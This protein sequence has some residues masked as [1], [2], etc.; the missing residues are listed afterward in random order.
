MKEQILV[1]KP[2]VVERASDKKQDYLQP[3]K[4][5]LWEGLQMVRKSGIRNETSK[6]IFNRSINH[7]EL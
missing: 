6:I 1:E 2:S 4:Q 5:F 3:L 7:L